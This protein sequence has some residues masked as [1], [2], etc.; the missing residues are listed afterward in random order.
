MWRKLLPMLLSPNANHWKRKGF[1]RQSGAS[2]AHILRN[3]SDHSDLEIKVSANPVCVGK[4]YKIRDNSVYQADRPNWPFVVHSGSKSL[5]GSDRENLSDRESHYKML[6][7]KRTGEFQPGRFCFGIFLPA[8]RSRT[9]RRNF[10]RSA[11]FSMSSLRFIASA[12]V[13]A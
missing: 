2:I 6:V 13:L 3:S 12:T 10:S 8:T 4:V 1:R 9:A 11:G 7:R 5:H